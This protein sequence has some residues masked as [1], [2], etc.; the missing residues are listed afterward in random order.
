MTIPTLS[1]FVVPFKR[2]GDDTFNL[3]DP[4]SNSTGA[5]TYTIINPDE[6]NPIATVIGRNVTIYQVLGTCT[7]VAFQEPVGSFT[8]AS[9]TAQFEVKKTLPT[10]TNFIIPSKI[11]GDQPFNI[12]DP[13]SN[14]NGVF[15]YLSGNT[16]V[17]TINNKT[18]TIVNVGTSIIIARQAGTANFDTRDVSFAFV[19]SPSPPTWYPNLV[20][21]QNGNLIIPT[22]VSD[23]VFRIGLNTNFTL[24]QLDV[25]R[26]PSNIRGIRP[27]GV[28]VLP[29]I[30]IGTNNQNPNQR[31]RYSCPDNS[32]AVTILPL[33]TSY[34]TASQTDPYDPNR[35]M[36]YND[37]IIINGLIDASNTV[38][39]NATSLVL[40]IYITQDAGS[41]NGI[42][43]ASKS[44]FF[45]LTL[46]A[47]PT[48]ISL[49]PSS[50]ISGVLLG[51]GGDR[52]TYT[53]EREYLQLF[54][55]LPF[56]EFITTN[57]KLIN[58]N[59]FDNTNAIYYLTRRMI[60]QLNDEYILQN[61]YISIQNNRIVFLNSTYNFNIESPNDAPVYNPISIAVYQDSTAFYQRS[62]FVGDSTFSTQSNK[63]T[64]NL[65]IVKS[66]PTFG[67]QVPEVNTGNPNTVYTLPNITKMTYDEPFEI[68]PPNSNNTDA[69][70]NFSVSS[71]ADDILKIKNE[72]GK[73][74]AY[75]YDAGIVKLTITQTSTRNFKSK[76]ATLLVYVNLISP[77]LI[78]CNTNIVYTN[79]YQ[80]EF[81]TRFKPPCPD[82]KF[83][84]TTSSGQTRNLTAVEV[85]ELYSERRKTEILKYNKN[86]GGLTKSQK[87]AKASRGEL[88][89]Q[90]GNENKY[91]TG[92]NGNSLI[93]PIQPSSRVYCGLTS[94]CGVPGKE[95]ILCYD[96]SINLYNLKR[97]YEYKAGLQTTTNI[98]TLALTPPRNLVADL[99]D[100]N[101]IILR[102]NSPISNGGLPITGYVIS[103]SI[104]NKT[105]IPY[106]SIFPN[107]DG[108]IDEISGERN[109][110]TVIVQDASG[111]IGVKG[112][113]NN[114]LYYISVFSANERG[115]SSVPATVN[116][117][118]SSS[119]SIISN[120]S[121]ADVDRKYLIIDLK[122]TNP[123][124]TS[125]SGGYNGPLIT[126][127][128]IHYKKT[129]DTTWVSTLVSDSTVVSDSTNPLIKKYT[130]RNLENKKAYELKIEPVNS[131]GTGP[132]SRIL[133]ARTLMAPSPP[134]NVVCSARYGIPPASTGA[135]QSSKINYITVTWDRPDNG[136]S[137]ISSYN[138]TTQGFETKLYTVSTT[139]QPNSY[140]Y[141]ITSLDSKTI[142]SRTY[143]LSLTSKNANYE[144]ISTNVVSVIIEPVTQRIVI[145]NIEFIYIANLIYGANITFSIDSYNYRD[146]PIS[147]FKVEVSQI[148]EGGSITY[149]TIK[150]LDNQN[151]NGSGEHKLFVP[152]VNNNV[153]IFQV[154]NPYSI[155]LN[156][157]FGGS[158]YSDTTKSLP[159]RITP[160]IRI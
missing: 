130:L 85:D 108:P 75:I 3:V 71:S 19:V 129:T 114:T 45:P 9:I 38:I 151:I 122:W 132:E 127:Y 79:P 111:S 82:Y 58:S 24:N 53:I 62:N 28:G 46:N 147:M 98:P 18:I 2:I 120:F 80:R 135:S 77:S 51:S 70:N 89:R 22:V 94:A 96:P 1:N 65:R 144:S 27:T 29:L 93:C 73:N 154:G 107:K 150:N 136:G 149:E 50:N 110:N 86:V 92:S 160:S 30:V 84:I 124:N 23:N 117:K 137:A 16:S 49:K 112:I 152:V 139:N 148:G 57:R 106:T 126:H 61:E 118:T 99:S 34:Q 125:S 157:N 48:V 15:T 39:R 72:N 134:L 100:N 36:N 78:N 31:I 142:E 87:Y 141:Y 128:M 156:A 119:P 21:A 88:M 116:I 143:S 101:R 33:S 7:V 52:S 5:F 12:T 42:P 67:G 121:L 10:I 158:G 90:I 102:W 97:T 32:N 95:R 47:V 11:N 140:T 103:Y 131:V 109:A 159:Y 133:T 35:L 6:N 74:M 146:N 26:L 115:L 13:T 66:E 54:L 91:L 63:T 44:V 25:A 138:I 76:T 123:V 14:S 20:Q 60:D 105:W 104:N 8:S 83:S 43:Y 59:D 145:S 81:W 55:D 155:T 69:S 153:T 68:I 4:S 56:S 113:Q 64:I 41:Y 17:A 37:V 40:N